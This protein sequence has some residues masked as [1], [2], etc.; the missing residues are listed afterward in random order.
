MVLDGPINGGSLKAY[1]DGMRLP[2]L[3]RGDVVITINLSSYI[4]PD[5]PLMLPPPYKPRLQSDQEA[6]RPPQSYSPQGRRV[7]LA[8]LCCLNRKIVGIFHPQDCADYFDSCGYPN[9][10]EHVQSRCLFGVV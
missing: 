6:I 7:S 2:D 5:A 10:K 4:R 9:G 3:T 8:G 1:V